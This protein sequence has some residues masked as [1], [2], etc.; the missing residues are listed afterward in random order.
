MPQ[1]T[2][3]PD[4][5]ASAKA[6]LDARAKAQGINT[7]GP[8]ARIALDRVVTEMTR[9]PDSVEHSI[10]Q[11]NMRNGNVPVRDMTESQGYEFGRKGHFVSGKWFAQS[12]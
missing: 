3:Y 7:K 10:K 9:K 12:R 11:R 4:E 1:W 8:R 6:N 5:R 2:Q